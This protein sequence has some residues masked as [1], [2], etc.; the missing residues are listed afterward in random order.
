MKSKTLPFLCTCLIVAF[1]AFTV[2]RSS[3]AAQ[4]AAPDWLEVSPA[5]RAA[6]SPDL[7]VGPDGSL[8]L[9]WVDKGT[10][11][12]PVAP[13]PAAAAGEHGQHGAPAAAAPRSHTH[14]AYYDLY[15]SRSTDGG[16]TFTTPLRVN[17]KPG[18]LWGFATSRPR[19]AVSKSGIIHIFY[20]GNRREPAAARQAVDARYT[21]ST[22][23]GKT[24]EAARTL[25]TEGQGYDD[26]EL[27]EAHCFGTL[28][29]APNGDVHAYWIDTRHMKSAEDNGAIYG[30]VSRNE[31]KSFDA[32]KLIVRDEACPCCQ[33]HVAFTPDSQTYL[34][35]RSV[36]ADGSRNAALKISTDRGKTFGASLNVSDKKWKIN[37]CPLK[38]L[39]MAA[40]NKGHVYAT[41]FAGE[42]N[43]PGVFFAV[44]KDKGRTF[45]PPLRVHEAASVSDHANLVATNEG[46]VRLVWDAKVGADKRVYLRTSTDFGQSFGPVQEIKAPPGN[47]DYPAIAATKGKM[48]LAWQFNNRIVFQ[49]LNDL[50]ATN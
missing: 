20:H 42:E 29:V 6:A 47:A 14:K 27:N 40:D 17:G 28:G 46:T 33:L 45:S 35:L 23:G 1:G 22:D 5:G 19:I 13:P 10:P 48:Y 34:S 37:A 18:E 39:L 26:G 7:A 8:N 31:G 32:E 50:V 2:D 16:R 36:S 15:F 12:P 49:T 24:F 11:R 4:V 25:N 38:P 44:S 9:L 43:P 3:S 30:V 41:W 21:R